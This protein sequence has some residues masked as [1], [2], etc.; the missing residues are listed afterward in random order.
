MQTA[1]VIRGTLKDAKT[2]ELDEPVDQLEGPVEVTLRPIEAERKVP[3][4]ESLSA[5][6][7]ITQFHEWL[8]AHDPN[9]PVLPAEALR[10]ENIYE[11]RL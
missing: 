11:D 10:R 2:I 5:E 9:L 4:Y 7:W 8:D 3:L 1:L 6:E